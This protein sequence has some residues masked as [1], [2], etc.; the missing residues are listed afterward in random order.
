MKDFYTKYYAAIKASRAHA[1]FCE[2]V[3]GRNL[4]QHGF[5]DMA[6]L[7]LLLKLTNIGPGNRALELG[8][9]CGLITEY[10]SDQSGAHITGLDF[11]PEAI[12]EARERTASKSDRL[13]FIVGDMNALD[14]P[15]QSFDTILSI[16]TLY[17]PSDLSRVIG[18]LRGALVPSGQMGILYG[19][20][21][22]PWT[23]QEQF[24]TSTL[25]PD[26]TPLG[27]ALIANGLRFT[28]IDLTEE[29]YRLACK[30]KEVLA[31]LK[32]QFEA[33]GIMFIYENRWGDSNGMSK[34]IELGLQ[35]RYLYH[36]K[37]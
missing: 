29:D 18:Q 12:E 26:C 22:E 31:E 20:G 32:P 27:C 28:T 24:D 4:G 8:C 33:E 14:L 34:A 13:A 17:F 5:A 2:R 9:G 11:I 1:E 3:F 21:W 23:P 7:D 15:P 16:D 19:H 36:I 10:L 35:K 37:A 6:Q 25:P 30:R